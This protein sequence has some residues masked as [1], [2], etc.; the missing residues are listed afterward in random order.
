M[1]V[2]S[3]ADLREHIGHEVEVA[4]YGG[5]AV[6]PLNVAIECMDEGVVLLDFDRPAAGKPDDPYV[7]IS[8]PRSVLAAAESNMVDLTP[9]D[10][11]DDETT[12]FDVLRRTI[13]F[14]LNMDPE[15]TGTCDVCST[16][17]SLSSARDH[18]V[19]EGRCWQH[20]SD[21]LSHESEQMRADYDEIPL[22]RY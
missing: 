22:R 5:D 3:Y 19:E 1:S 9:D 14:A 8:L 10:V 20:C 18:C 13:Y 12:A 16:P 6:W 17:Y 7:T 21:E 4:A 2:R 11:F 15:D